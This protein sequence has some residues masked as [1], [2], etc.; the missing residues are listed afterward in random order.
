VLKVDQNTL[1]TCVYDKMT[2]DGPLFVV[3]VLVR[4]GPKRMDS[5]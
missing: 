4:A 2:I 5:R 3:V 1:S